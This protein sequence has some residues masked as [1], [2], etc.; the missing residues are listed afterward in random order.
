VVEQTLRTNY[1]GTLETT[2]ALLPL[3]RP[4]GRVVNV[5]SSMGGLQRYAP[6]LRSA[7]LA[8]GSEE[9]VTALMERFHA[10]VAAG[11][12]GQQG[13]PSNAYAVSKAGVIALTRTLAAEQ[14]GGGRGVLVNACCPGWV[15]T[16]MTRGGGTKT[17]DEGGQ[18]PVLLALGDIGGKAGLFWRS[19]RVVKW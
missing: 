19:E 14:E 10:A 4:G 6:A 18:T 1:H 7:F 16:D 8:A 17:P 15:R 5:A 13:W 9:Q 3:L 11:T 2:R 12:E